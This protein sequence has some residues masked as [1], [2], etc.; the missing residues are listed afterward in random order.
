MRMDAAALELFRLQRANQDDAFLAEPGEFVAQVRRVSRAVIARHRNLGRV[1]CLQRR[2]VLSRMIRMR[3]AKARRS[4]SIRWPT[5]SLTHHSRGAGFQ[6]AM[7][8][9]SELSNRVTASPD[10]SSVPATSLG[11]TPAA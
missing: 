1:P 11:V 7:A 8:G 2:F 6:R 10:A 5:H 4:A 9:G 3:P